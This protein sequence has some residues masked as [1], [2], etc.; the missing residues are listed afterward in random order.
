MYGK[1]LRGAELWKWPHTPRFGSQA[2]TAKACCVAHTLVRAPPVP[3]A[4]GRRGLSWCVD[5]ELPRDWINI[6]HLLRQSHPDTRRGPKGSGLRT[7]AQRHLHLFLHAEGCSQRELRQFWSLPSLWGWRPGQRSADLHQAAPVYPP[8]WPP[9]EPWASSLTES[10]TMIECFSKEL[11]ASSTGPF[12]LPI[13]RALGCLF[14]I[15]L[16]RAEVH[17]ASADSNPAC[18]S[19]RITPSSASLTTHYWKSSPRTTWTLLQAWSLMSSCIF[20]LPFLK[21]LLHSVSTWVGEWAGRLAFT[22]SLSRRENL[23]PIGLLFWELTLTSE[24][25]TLGNIF[26]QHILTD[27][28]LQTRH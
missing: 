6:S 23:A 1:Q 3:R 2:I 28:L 14:L 21:D 17:V 7:E 26:L 10:E 16:T 27:A 9:G 20:S 8:Q 5:C 12:F 22:T 25:I 24:Y 19:Y 13:W 15:V 18:F 11:E 4:F